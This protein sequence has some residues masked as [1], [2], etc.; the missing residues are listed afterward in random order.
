[1]Y[2]NAIALRR[3]S[4]G[5]AAGRK[6]STMPAPTDTSTKPA[7]ISGL[8]PAFGGG[9]SLHNSTVTSGGPPNTSGMTY[10]GRPPVLK[11]QMMH[12][13]PAAPRAP[14]I[15]AVTRPVL[16]KFD[17]WPCDPSAMTG[18]MT[19]IKKYAPPTQSTPFSGLPS[20]VCPKCRSAPEAP[21]DSTAPATKMIQ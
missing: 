6:Y 18:M 14:A 21:Q 4:G 20:G 13:A 16:S 15:V 11:A 9:I 2:D 12:A 3:R 10:T 5:H 1:A 7:Y 19:P 8:M 17:I